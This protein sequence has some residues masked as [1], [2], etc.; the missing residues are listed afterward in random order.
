MTRPFVFATAPFAR[1][2]LVEAEHVREPQ[3][4]SDEK[5]MKLRYAGVR[6]LC[7]AD[8]PAKEAAIYERSTKTVR[9]VECLPETDVVAR[10]HERAELGPVE[11]ISD[12]SGTAGSSARREYERRKAKE[13]ERLRRN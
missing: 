10:P 13:V 1:T 9:C 6:R 12:S 5:R 2:K 11:V 3:G 4:R 7:G 8:L